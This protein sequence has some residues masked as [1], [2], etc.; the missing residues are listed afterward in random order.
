MTSTT[1]KVRKLRALAASPNQHE[2]AAALAKA[3]RLE[4]KTSRGIAL[5]IA[6]LL[7]QQGLRVRVR[8]H[9]A[10][11]RTTADVKISYRTSRA[12][13]PRAPQHSIDIEITEYGE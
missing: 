10:E 7:E 9:G 1:E 6:T 8:R 12:R 13:R 4:F 3:H 2:A 11:D 5:A